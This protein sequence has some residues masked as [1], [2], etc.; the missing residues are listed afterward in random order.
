MQAAQPIIDP[1]L[2]LWDKAR[3]LLAAELGVPPSDIVADV[4]RHYVEQHAPAYAAML[5]H[6]DDALEALYD[7]AHQRLALAFADALPKQF[8]PS[9]MLIAMAAPIVVHAAL[10]AGA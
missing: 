1:D 6:E 10:E 4:D 7:E 8:E 3:G 9:H 5:L 2:A